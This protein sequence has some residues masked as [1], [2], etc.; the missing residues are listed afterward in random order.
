MQLRTNQSLSER[1]SIFW[2]KYTI[3]H[4]LITC[5]TILLI[6]VLTGVNLISSSLSSV[7]NLQ[8]NTPQVLEKVSFLLKYSDK[9]EQNT[10][11]SIK[12]S[13]LNS[14]KPITNITLT[15]GLVQR[16]LNKLDKVIQLWLEKLAPL[17]NYSLSPYGFE[18][19]FEGKSFTTDLQIFFSELDNLIIQ[20]ESLWS[21][22][23][24]YRTFLSIFGNQ[25][26]QQ[27]LSSIDE[28]IKLLKILNNNQ[29][30]ILDLLGHYTTKQIVI[31]NQNTGEARSTGGFYGSYLPLT[32]S[33]GK[34][35]VGQSQ[36]IYWIDGS[37][38]PV[39]YAHPAYSY[40]S[41]G[42]ERTLTVGSRDLNFTPCFEV[43]GS[44]IEQEFSTSDNGYTIDHL[45][46]ITPQF[47][48]NLLPLDFVLN[49]DGIG[50]INRNNFFDEIERLTS[51][52]FATNSNPKYN[53]SNIFKSLLDSFESIV[54]SQGVS[55]TLNTIIDS[56]QSR[57][58]MMW[59][60][61]PSL[62]E[63]FKSINLGSDQVCYNQQKENFIT[64]LMINFSGDK[65]NLI[66]QNTYAL[67]STKKIG[68]TNF[69]LKY[70]EYI[71]PKTFLQRG[72]NS[73]TGQMFIGVQLPPNAT[74]FSVKGNDTI[75]RSL[76]KPFS[77]FYQSKENAIEVK[78]LAEV[79]II[80]QTARNI[81]N[82]FVYTQ[83]DGSLV[84]GSF[85]DSKAGYNQVEFNFSLPIDSYEPITFYGQPGVN[86][87][88]LSLGKGVK[89][90]T[91]PS[92]SY[93]DNPLQIQKGIRIYPN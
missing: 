53:I 1:P 51:L 22:F 56:I 16:D 69:H 6:V 57:D 52:S 18:N 58:M 7:Q 83:I 5:I 10:L 8:E 39:N 79:K 64:P 89:S 34:I 35:T 42:K 50:P 75:N 12:S 66:S 86:L 68:K 24:I 92:E 73:S 72:F 37:K 17:Q 3:K 80:N 93:F 62:I 23:G 13:I 71:P 32:I 61:N 74:N 60:K 46:M 59:F 77:S 20:T 33:Q 11:D 9:V 38:N 26:A 47:I 88:A 48:Q 67:S 21:D 44:L 15:E 31:F 30:N 49:V 25:K 36:S 19:V 65:R 54:N 28:G 82:G 55:K 84:L 43:T 85:I 63:F 14:L 29:D 78:E 41:Y 45:L 27:I 76:I 40:Y 90:V 91:W 70:Q 81:P 2:S 4:H 87:P